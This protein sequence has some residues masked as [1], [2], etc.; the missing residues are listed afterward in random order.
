MK[1]LRPRGVQKGVDLIQCLEA[2]VQVEA[3][4]VDPSHCLSYWVI[5]RNAISFETQEVVSLV[6]RPFS[7][8]SIIAWADRI[9][10]CI[11]IVWQ[12]LNSS[13][14]Q[15]VVFHLSCSGHYHTRDHTAR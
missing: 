4:E 6:K 13:I 9:S 2:S 8:S 14:Y 12:A 7:T 11:C 1:V 15:M 10:S 5:S 3:R